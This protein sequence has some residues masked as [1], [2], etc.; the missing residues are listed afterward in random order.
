MESC[1]LRST[2]RGVSIASLPRRLPPVIC[3]WKGNH[4][5]I[6]AKLHHDC[7]HGDGVGLGLFDLSSGRLELE[8]GREHVNNAV[9]IVASASGSH[10]HAT[11]LGKH[12][13]PD[14]ITPSGSNAIPFASG[15]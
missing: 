9:A 8:A 13:S 2:E 4:D 1:L 10:L 14:G 3:R 12:G 6:A 5:A 7:R 15:L 11:N